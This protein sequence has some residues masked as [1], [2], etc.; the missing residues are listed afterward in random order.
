VTKNV[1]KEKVVIL[2]QHLNE[3]EDIKEKY[4]SKIGYM[5]G[6]PKNIILCIKFKLL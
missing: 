3:I 1:I 4:N 2:F 5:A 6:M